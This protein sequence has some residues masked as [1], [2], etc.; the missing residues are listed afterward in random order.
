MHRGTLSVEGTSPVSE[1]LLEEALQRAADYFIRRELNPLVCYGAHADQADR[2]FSSH[3]KAAELLAN[4]V[5]WS[6]PDYK[7]TRI[8]LCIEPITEFSTS[9]PTETE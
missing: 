1:E 7:E 9:L 5:L 8:R 2:L 3:W 4:T 6:Y